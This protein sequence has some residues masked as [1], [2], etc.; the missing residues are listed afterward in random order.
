MGTIERAKRIAGMFE[1]AVYQ[2]AAYKI[3]QDCANCNRR[4][5]CSGKLVEHPRWS[6]WEINWFKNKYGKKV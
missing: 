3:Y 2:K 6:E 1:N 4:I 5:I